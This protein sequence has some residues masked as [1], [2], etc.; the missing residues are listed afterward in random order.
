M[1]SN[2]LEN[3]NSSAPRSPQPSPKKVTTNWYQTLPSKKSVNHPRG[4]GE[5]K[6]NP[7]QHFFNEDSEGSDDGSMEEIPAFDEF[8][9]YRSRAVSV[10]TPTCISSPESYEHYLARS[11][12][13]SFT[14]GA[15]EDEFDC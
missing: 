1:N 6:S 13:M 11:R 9:E 2:E 4:P 8:G 5:P 7:P 3:K 10:L 15:T 14:S 12:N